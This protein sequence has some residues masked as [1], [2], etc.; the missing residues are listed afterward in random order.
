MR[1][2]AAAVT[3]A[4]AMGCMPV[5]HAEEPAPD[6]TITT[7]GERT[8][9]AATGGENTTTG[10]ENTEQQGDRKPTTGE[11]SSWATGS[12]QTPAGLLFFTGA[13]VLIVVAE[14]YLIAAELLHLPTPFEIKPPAIQR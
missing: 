1:R 6:T 11:L 5:A 13:A 10:G 9:D 2:I 7:P 4:L 14:L 12:V 3:I 8:D